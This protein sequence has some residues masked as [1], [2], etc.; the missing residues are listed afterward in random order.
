MFWTVDLVTHAEAFH[1]QADSL[2]AA[3]NSAIKEL[4]NNPSTDR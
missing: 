3:M 1:G 4:F 2:D